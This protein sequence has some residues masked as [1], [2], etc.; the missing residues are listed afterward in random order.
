M[1]Y[2]TRSLTNSFILS[3]A[4]CVPDFPSAVKERHLTVCPHGPQSSIQSGRLSKLYTAANI[5]VIWYVNLQ[6]PSILCEIYFPA[7]C[8]FVYITS[9]NE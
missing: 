9:F 8:G 4:Q 5:H 7:F 1:G 2:Y 3:L 6:P